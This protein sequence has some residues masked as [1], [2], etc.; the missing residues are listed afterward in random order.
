MSPLLRDLQ[1]PECVHVLLN[2]LPLTG[3]VAALLGLT[4][5]LALRNRAALSL[6]M[7]LVSLFSLSA[8]PV[9]V[10]GEQGYNR[11]YSM[12]DQEGDAYLDRHK[13]LGERWI[14]L[15][16][17]TAGAGA[18]GM[19]AGWR[20]PKCQRALALA[21]A[22]L[23]AGSLIAGAVIASAGGKVRHPEFRNRPPPAAH[24]GRVSKAKTQ[25][26]SSTPPMM[27]IGSELRTTPPMA[28]RNARKARA[29][30]TCSPGLRSVESE[31]LFITSCERSA[32]DS[33]PAAPGFRALRSGLRPSLN[34]PRQ[35]GRASRRI[36]SAPGDQR[37][38]GAD[39]FEAPCPFLIF[40]SPPPFVTSASRST[41][42]L[43]SLFHAAR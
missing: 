40:D 27:A 8:W 39:G 24:S 3:L 18:L 30:R 7:G 16:Y 21:T 43:A 1:R 35:A 10:Y 38:T 34:L 23:A 37:R 28:A 14:W 5:C 20:W 15:F 36:S 41:S 12:A 6:G 32:C 19:A 17:L 22:V 33:N 9:Y 42:I 26:K 4:G 31:L 2:H 13:E 11:V 29:N 25:S